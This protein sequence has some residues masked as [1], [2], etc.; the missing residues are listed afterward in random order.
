VPASPL[1]SVVVPAYNAESTIGAT[2]RSVLRQ[3]VDDFEVVVVD[4]G[5]SD[6]T[7]RCVEPF[8]TD[9]RVALHRKANG[10]PADARN[11]GIAATSAP[12]VSFLDSDDLWMP[13]Y[14][15]TMGAVLH[16]DPEV[17]VGY[18]DAWVVDDRTR[19]IRRLSAMARHN[20]PVPPPASRD[21]FFAVLLDRNFV[22]NSVTIRRS[23]LDEA[24]GFDSRCVPSEDFE[25]WLRLASRD[26]TFARPAGFLAVYRDRGDSLSAD[27]TRMADA[28]VRVLRIAV[29]EY[30]LEGRRATATAERLARA[31]GRLA[32]LSDGRRARVRARL[33]RVPRAFVKSPRL[34]FLW[35]RSVP[36]EVT[37]GVPD[38]FDDG[39]VYGSASVV[40]PNAPLTESAVEPRVKPS[41]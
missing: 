23:V 27:E 17:A 32:Q 25:L 24:G 35:A 12:L 37:A 8:L 39:A 6:S 19:R 28:L 20:P 13:R 21:E 3:T 14:L 10:G 33:S 36:T 29:E 22:Y 40:A 34:P 2:L 30:G 7:A 41:S 11:A 4:D 9:P 38:L 16:G 1:Y 26:L 31:E 15:E 18:T 5:S